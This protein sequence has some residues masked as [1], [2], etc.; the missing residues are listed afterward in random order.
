MTHLSQDAL[1]AWRDHPTEETRAQV[2]EHLAE[3]AECAAVYAEV[4]RTQAVAASPARFNPAGFTAIGL[5]VGMRAHSPSLASRLRRLSSDV[6]TTI[7]EALFRSPVQTRLVLVGQ[8]A[9]ILVLGGL[10]LVA[11]RQEPSYA[12][13]SGGDR[14][15]GGARLTV[16]FQPTATADAIRGTLREVGGTI[17][18]G[19]SAAGIY[20]VEVPQAPGADAGTG[21]AIEKL[22]RNA[23][24]ISFAERQ[25]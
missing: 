3:C 7:W 24:V 13:L 12:T 22:R 16:T 25:P 19:P 15:T 21:A 1:I 4:I 11:R 23:S 14:T 10:L 17:V 2:T 18:S 8:F 5:A 20:V 6:A 9:L